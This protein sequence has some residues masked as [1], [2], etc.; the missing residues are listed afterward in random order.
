[1][2]RWF[3]LSRWLKH[4]PRV[5]FGTRRARVC[6]RMYDRGDMIHKKLGH[7]VSHD[8]TE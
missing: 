7:I 2:H 1:M 8:A 3:L 6:D 4:H 5:R